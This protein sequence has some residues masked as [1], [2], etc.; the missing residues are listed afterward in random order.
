MSTIEEARAQ[1]A[2][3]SA[4]TS[5]PARR[6]CA[7]ASAP[8]AWPTR[9][10]WPTQSPATAPKAS[11]SVERSGVLRARGGRP[12]SVPGVR[13]SFH[14]SRCGALLAYRATFSPQQSADQWGRDEDA[15]DVSSLPL[16]SYRPSRPRPQP[17]RAVDETACP[18]PFRAPAGD[19]KSVGEL[20][21]QERGQAGRA[22]LGL[23]RVGGEHVVAV[24]RA[25]ALVDGDLDPRLDEGRGEATGVLADAVAAGDLDLDRG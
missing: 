19:A 13:G 14:L 23:G 22:D 1:V 11:A 24:D 20:G 6:T 8:H 12:R 16:V 7:P 18:F 25:V 3:E 15:G 5:A 9:P 17:A 21:V 4:T 10:R 2:S